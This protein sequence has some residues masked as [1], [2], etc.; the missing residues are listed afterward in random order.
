MKISIKFLFI[1]IYFDKIWLKSTDLFSPSVERFINERQ[2][3]SDILC[4][5]PFERK[6]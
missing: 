6:G 4:A 5:R 2:V 3:L 1:Y